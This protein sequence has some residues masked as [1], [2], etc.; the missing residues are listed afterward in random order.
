MRSPAI[1]RFFLFRTEATQLDASTGPLRV[2]ATLGSDLQLRPHI[3]KRKGALMDGT[4]S[5]PS[6]PST[7]ASVFTARL[8]SPSQLIAKTMEPSNVRTLGSTA[9]RLLTYVGP[10]QLD[11]TDLNRAI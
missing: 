6:I 7:L 11:S 3:L 1:A 9:R 4:I 10:M 8:L 2:L 5:I